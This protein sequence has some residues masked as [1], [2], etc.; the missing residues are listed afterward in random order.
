[1]LK[2]NLKKAK[3]PLFQETMSYFLSL[4]KNNLF[5]DLFQKQKYLGFRELFYKKK[6]SINVRS[7][8][9]VYYYRLASRYFPCFP[10]CGGE[11]IYLLIILFHWCSN[12]NIVV[13]ALN[14]PYLFVPPFII[15]RIQGLDF[16]LIWFHFFNFSV[17]CCF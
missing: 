4:K 6:F 11:S 5:K 8:F 12:S 3:R 10:I 16:L 1:M 15:R 14:R 7:T 17:T 13:F 2:L 9:F